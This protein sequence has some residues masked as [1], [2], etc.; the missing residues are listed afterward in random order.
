[1][2]EIGQRLAKSP[3]NFDLFVEVADSGDDPTNA[4]VPWPEKCKETNFGT[5]TL[6]QRVDVQ[7]PE[8]WKMIF[9]PVPRVD[10]ID[11]AG[12]PLTELRSDIYLLSGRRRR[13]AK[14]L[15]KSGGA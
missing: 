4:T 14:Q 5:L 7:E 12:D 1:M 3:A 10:G 13:E 8:R 6:T 11:S 2:D 15:A 9:D